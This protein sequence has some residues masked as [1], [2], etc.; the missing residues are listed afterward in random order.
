MPI[1][2]RS[3]FEATIRQF[4]EANEVDPNREE[5]E[6]KQH[7]KELL[8]AHRMTQWLNRL[9]PAAS[10]ALQLAVRAQHICRWEIPRNDFPDG[11]VG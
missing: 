6:G 2:D 7:P 3:R 5:F 11:R 8:Y 4:D 10:E 9:Y 1:Q